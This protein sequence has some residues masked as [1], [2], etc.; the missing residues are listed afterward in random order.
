MAVVVEQS[1]VVASEVG[2]PNFR[3]ELQGLHPFSLWVFAFSFREVGNFSLWTP[4]SHLKKR[5][6]LL[7]IE[8]WLVNRDPY[9][10]LL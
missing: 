1:A 4:L 9:S 10:E 5:T 7:S 8:S 3:I 6:L 2:V